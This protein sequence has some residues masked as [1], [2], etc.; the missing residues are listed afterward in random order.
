MQERE[1]ERGKDEREEG[2]DERYV[3]E[4]ERCVHFNLHME[5]ER[6]REIDKYRG[7][8]SGREGGRGRERDA[9]VN[10]GE[11]L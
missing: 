1:K 10:K 11:D 5:G 3:R 7:R 8:R 9:G 4:E 6:E 2:T